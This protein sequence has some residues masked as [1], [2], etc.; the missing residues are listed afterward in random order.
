MNQPLILGCKAYELE[1]GMEF[2]FDE[3]R[4]W[5]TAETVW[6]DPSLDVDRIVVNYHDTNGA[7]TIELKSRDHVLLE[8]NWR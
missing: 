3:G 4:T 8:R 6:E 5:V 1:P 2:S 7:G